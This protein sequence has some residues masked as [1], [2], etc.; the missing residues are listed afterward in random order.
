MTNT[1]TST[2]TPVAASIVWSAA[3]NGDTAPYVAADTSTKAKVRSYFQNAANTALAS[4]DFDT[5][6][7]MVTALNAVKG[8]K[9]SAPKSDVDFT[10]VLADK[11]TELSLAAV[12][13]RSLVE[14]SD[15]DIDTERLN[16]LLTTGKLTDANRESA[17]K[18]VASIKLGSGTRAPSS[19]LQASLDAAT[20]EKGNFYTVAQITKA[21]EL[22]SAGAV[23]ARLFPASGTCTLVGWVPV[24]RTATSAQGARYVGT[25]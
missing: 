12:I 23:A 15:L 8:S 11:I 14:I 6:K 10:Q 19:N 2:A 24:E 22:P 7:T 3:L 17:T 4:G 13:L 16:E 25:K 20:F 21:A 1:A 18:L 9:A 5:A